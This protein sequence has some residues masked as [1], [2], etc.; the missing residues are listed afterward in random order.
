MASAN[1]IYVNST[2]VSFS[3]SWHV[4]IVASLKA[5]GSLPEEF[6]DVFVARVA[7]INPDGSTRYVIEAA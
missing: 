6:D 3:E 5:S 2:G 1:Y 4:A 7:C